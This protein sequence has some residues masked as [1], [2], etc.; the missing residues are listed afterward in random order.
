ML[1][2]TGEL[3]PSTGKAEAW[4]PRGGALEPHLEGQL[5][6]WQAD[7]VGWQGGRALERVGEY[8]DLRA[9]TRQ[10]GLSE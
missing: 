5:G 2:L 7:E 1:R 6:V 10:P 9:W 3:V 4:P 8:G